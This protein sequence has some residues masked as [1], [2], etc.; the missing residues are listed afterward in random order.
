MKFKPM[1]ILTIFTMELFCFLL[2]FGNWQWRRYQYKLASEAALPAPYATAQMVQ[3]FPREFMK[4]QLSGEISEKTIG[5]FATANGQTGYRHFAQFKT[6]GRNY[7]I[8][9]GW[10]NEADSKQFAHEKATK[11]IEGVLRSSHRPNAFFA[12]NQ[13]ERHLYYWPELSLLAREF[14]NSSYQEFYVAVS[15][16]DLKNTGNPTP[17]PW[18]DSK[19]ASYI[20]PARHLG[21][22]LTWWG[23][24]ISLIGVYIAMHIKAGLITF[25][26]KKE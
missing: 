16:S 24:A 18:A 7:L 4:V 25:R 20:E 11:T 12:A 8:D 21:Y 17:N 2:S 26:S 10:L 6:E 1:P 15:H 5:V 9:L 19:G 23:L 14:A 22:A 3:S 13:P